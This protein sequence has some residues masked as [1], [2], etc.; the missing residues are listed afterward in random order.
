M[1]TLTRIDGR[2]LTVNADEIETVESS[3]DTTVGLIS[4]RK[5]IVIESPEE[6][7]ERVIAYRQ[8]CFALILGQGS[9]STNNEI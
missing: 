6:I 9:Q 4:G 3:H 8:K 1:I 2:P 7:T 5:I